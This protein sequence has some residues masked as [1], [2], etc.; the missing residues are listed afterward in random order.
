M[1]VRVVVEQGFDAASFVDNVKADLEIQILREMRGIRMDLVNECRGYNTYQDQTT[2]LRSSIGGFIVVDGVIDSM[3]E[4]EQL[5][6]KLK[7]TTGKVEYNGGE[8]GRA[9][10][11][12][13]AANETQNI[14]LGIVAGMQYAQAV[15]SKGYDVIS[16]STILS[17][18]LIKEALKDIAENE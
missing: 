1:G 4:F 12:E 14:V 10:A 18:R 2:N 9:Y 16:G 15:E 5:P 13:L 3:S 8:R 7:D 11:E 17:E 6:P